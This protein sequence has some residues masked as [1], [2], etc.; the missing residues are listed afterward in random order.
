[1]SEN[2]E[3]RK[4]LIIELNKRAVDEGHT[5]R[6]F[7]A[8]VPMMTIA[9][10]NAIGDPSKMMGLA[11]SLIRHAM[12]VFYSSCNTSHDL[13]IRTAEDVEKIV[14]SM[15]TACCE[16]AENNLA[17]AQRQGLQVPQ[18]LIDKV[19]TLPSDPSKR[20]DVAP[21]DT[22]TNIPQ[23]PKSVADIMSVLDNQDKSKVNAVEAIE[24]KQ[25]AS[26]QEKK[27]EARIKAKVSE[28]YSMSVG[29]SM[30][31]L[32]QLGNGKGN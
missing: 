26:V 25:E 29:S 11:Q 6:Y 2:D 17:E 1:M 24:E 4:V 30:S 27:Q 8:F 5:E 7:D 23:K 15:W 32:K 18:S 19:V 16:V 12:V 3:K 9:F 28:L 10:S 31:E 22:T 13:Q 20:V 21:I 14:G